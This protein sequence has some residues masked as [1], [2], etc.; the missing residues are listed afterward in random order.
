MLDDSA[1]LKRLQRE[2]NELKDKQK[3]AGVS[4]EEFQRIE[5]EKENLHSQLAALVEE[6]E[7]QR[8]MHCTFI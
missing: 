8:V 2:L 3:S 1:K 4:D 6:K 7:L 5:S